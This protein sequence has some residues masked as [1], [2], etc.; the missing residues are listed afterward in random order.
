MQ[1]DL[2]PVIN[3]PL[4]CMNWYFSG[5]IFSKYCLNQ[6]PTTSEILSGCACCCP[7]LSQLANYFNV[8]SAM[9]ALP[10]CVGCAVLPGPVFG[11]G[12][13]RGAQC[14]HR[15]LPFLDVLCWYWAS[16][17]MLGMGLAGVAHSA[18]GWL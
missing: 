18:T 14:W 6:F 17:L 1:K 12:G 3:C 2:V 15:T 5:V 11:V 13:G 7:L 4:C 10:P 8:S 16:S 9:G